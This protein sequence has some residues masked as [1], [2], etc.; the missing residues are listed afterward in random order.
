[1]TTTKIVMIVVVVVAVIAIVVA[2]FVAG[3]FGFVFYSIGSSDAANTARAYLREN[4]KLKQDIG[5]VKDFG[6][7]VNGS[8]NVH[9]G[10]GEATLKLKVIGSRHTVAATVELAYRRGYAWRVVSAS[11]QN[12]Q[13]QLVQ[14]LDPYDSMLIPIPRAA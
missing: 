4:E 12:E 14:L 13:G 2:V 5:E 6:S 7:F 8:V 11:Y 9:N 3:L 1:M 10:D